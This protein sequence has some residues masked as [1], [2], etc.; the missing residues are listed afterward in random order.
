MIVIM[1]NVAPLQ[2]KSKFS[3][4]VVHVTKINNGN[5]NILFNMQL[6]N[7]TLLW[8]QIRVTDEDGT[9]V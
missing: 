7:S 5:F 6:N 9:E 3:Y 2:L 8:L 4:K 1:K